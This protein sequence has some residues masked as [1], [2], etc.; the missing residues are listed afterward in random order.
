MD[1][2]N[3]RY[4]ITFIDDHSRYMYHFLFHNKS[5]ALG[6]F[7]IFK[8]E[9]EKQCDKQIKIVRSDKVVNIMVDTLR[10]DKHLV[11]LQSFFKSM[12]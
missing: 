12:R 11:H 9:V 8:V 4:F 6:I 2:P 3:Q 7:K 5:E 1:S 10:L